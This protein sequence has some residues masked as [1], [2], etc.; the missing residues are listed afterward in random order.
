MLRVESCLTATVF[1][2]IC[3]I[4]MPK[5]LNKFFSWSS[6]PVYLKKFWLKQLFVSGFQLYGMMLAVRQ[7]PQVII[8]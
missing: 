1:S 7:K 4:F 8:A 5:K 6:K 2:G 3:T